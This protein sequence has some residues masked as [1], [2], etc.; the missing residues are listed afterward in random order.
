MSIVDTIIIVLLLFGGLL[1]FKAGFIKKITSFI[2]LFVIIVLSFI[3]KNHVS[4][5]FYEYLPFF[6]FGGII[7]GVQVINVL[8]YEIVA[9]III[10]IALM[11]VLRMILVI[12]GLVEKILQATI[13]LSLPSKI[14]GLVVGVLESYIYVYIGILILSLPIFNISFINDSKLC[15]VILKD[16]PIISE[17]ASS[18]VD[19]YLEVYNIL[20][21]NSNK[22]NEQLNEEILV[23]L[24]DKEIITKDSTERLIDKNK[25]TVNNRDFL[26]NY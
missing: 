4:F 16:T 23:I 10:F 21:D 14:L 26:N 12:T 1:G 15:S 24:L 18:T 6:N 7:K 22:T 2:G 17:I 3:L 8:F 9:F 20:H 5:L 11:C 19:T 25:I 13:F